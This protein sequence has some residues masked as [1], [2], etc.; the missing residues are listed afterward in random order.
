MANHEARLL[1]SPL[2]SRTRSEEPDQGITNR[3]S[4]APDRRRCRGERRRVRLT[5]GE[6]KTR[7]IRKSRK[8][9][10]SSVGR[11][12]VWIGRAVEPARPAEGP[13]SGGDSDHEERK[14]GDEERGRVRCRRRARR[15]GEL[16]SRR[17]ARRRRVHDDPGIELRTRRSARPARWYRGR[18]RVSAIVRGIGKTKKTETTRKSGKTRR[19]GVGG[20]GPGDWAGRA[21]GE[22]R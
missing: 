1:D 15:P 13:R 11:E 16:W 19:S 12:A 17:L 4:P 21:T 7:K 8:T 14:P 18:R 20:R 6:L 3:T 5:F 9:R 10:R 22:A 2:G